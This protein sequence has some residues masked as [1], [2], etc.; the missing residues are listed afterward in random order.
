MKNILVTG[1]L[2]QIG[3]ELV[4]ALW[5]RYGKEHVLATDIRMP[6]EEALDGPFAVLNV[7]DA[8]DWE[9]IVSK[10]RFD[11]IIHL[12]AILSA[13]GEND[14]LNTWHIN[15]SGTMHALEVA[16]THGMKIFAPSSIAVFGPETPKTKT[17][18]YTVMRPQTM[19]GVSKV[20]LE[21]LFDYYHLKFGVDT[22]SMRFP[23]IISY[24]TPPGGGTTDYAVEMIRAAV[25]KG[26]YT[27]FVGPK[28][29]LDF[30]YMPDAI[31][32]IITLLERDSAPLKHRNAY[33]VTAMRFT[34]EALG[35]EIKRH[36]PAFSWD[37][38]I[39]PLRQAIA[40]SWPAA[41]DPHDA[42]QEWNFKP[43][44]DLSLM[45]EDM[46]RALQAAQTHALHASN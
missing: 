4:P 39:D 14:P 22:R 46:I 44:Y 45:V 8:K 30:M 40:D 29:Q 33:N 11:T 43:S 7:T 38:A 10:G 17:P 9:R 36:L 27:S 32:A 21:L 16:R 2:G 24:Q 5:A 26:H 35:M 20:A 23:G 19:Y 25:L 12:A 42:I 28:T 6:A 1:A 37:Y 31:E 41:I 18:S 34:P 15:M 3:S 13:R